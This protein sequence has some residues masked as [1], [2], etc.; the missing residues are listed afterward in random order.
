MIKSLFIANW[1]MHK[2][3]PATTQFVRALKQIFLPADQV[4]VICPPYTALPIMQQELTGSTIVY[5]A[6]NMHWANEG[7]YTGEISPEMLQALGCSYVIIGHSERRRDYNETDE[8]VQRKVAAALHHGLVPIVCVGESLD[9]RNHDETM[10]VIQRQVSIAC[11]GLLPTDVA[12][13]VFAY[14]PIWAIGSGQ[15]ATP[16]YAATVHTLIRQ[17]TRPEVT[18]I[19]GGSVNADNIG[20]F[21]QQPSIQGALIG[22][23]SV[24]V[25]SFQQL[26]AGST[27]NRI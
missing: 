22:G 26:L 24:E 11:H 4:V 16:E 13:L 6:Q 7:A 15:A 12:R 2:T 10:A 3:N 8:T 14:E 5:G 20:Q 25:E 18:I 19:Y 23:A 9:E 21:M 27:I 1:K 17:L